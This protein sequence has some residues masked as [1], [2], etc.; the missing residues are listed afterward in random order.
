MKTCS[1]DGSDLHGTPRLSVLTSIWISNIH[2]I[3]ESDACSWHSP[4]W[5]F[6][7]PRRHQLDLASCLHHAFFSYRCHIPSA[8]LVS[9]TS[10]VSCIS[11]NPK[12]LPS[13]LLLIWSFPSHRIE[14]QRCT[15]QYHLSPDR[16]TTENREGLSKTSCI[17][18]WP[19]HAT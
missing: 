9:R 3:K 15:L 18:R 11:S 4:L 12:N 13:L 10:P 6:E 17:P 1:F 5:H 2:L 14:P 16:S 7:V 8:A 19:G